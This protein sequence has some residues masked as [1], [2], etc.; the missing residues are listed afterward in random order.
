[1]TQEQIAKEYNRLLQGK[2]KALTENACFVKFQI[3][4]NKGINSLEDVFLSNRN[5]KASSEEEQYQHYITQLQ[6][7][8]E[9]DAHKE[10][11]AIG[12]RLT[13]KSTRRIN[14]LEKQMEQFRK[15]HGLEPD[16]RLSAHAVPTDEG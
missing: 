6:R 3:H 5:I 12:K 11:L 2:M 14:E 10:L 16:G 1:M 7:Y 15:R 9:M 8:Y 13:D 4:L